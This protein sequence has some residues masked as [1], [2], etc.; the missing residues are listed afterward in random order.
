MVVKGFVGSFVSSWDVGVFGLGRKR[1]IGGEVLED[2]EG[3]VVH[4][5]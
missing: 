2:G 5:V 1:W 4:F 3:V